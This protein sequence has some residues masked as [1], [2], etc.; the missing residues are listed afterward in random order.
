MKT[1]SDTNGS[2]AIV[3]PRPNRVQV[4]TRESSTSCLLYFTPSQA[5][6]LAAELLRAADEADSTV[7]KTE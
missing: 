4:V 7:G 5:R 2:M 6:E 1:V 3:T